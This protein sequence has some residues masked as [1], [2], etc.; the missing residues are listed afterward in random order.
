MS[1]NDE[2][3]CPGNAAGAS[4]HRIPADLQRTLFD[5]LINSDFDATVESAL[6]R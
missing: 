5:K 6:S 2:F 1:M 4:R 3:T